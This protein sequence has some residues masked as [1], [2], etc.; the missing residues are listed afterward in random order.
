MMKKKIPVSGYKATY[1]H[2]DLLSTCHR[3]VLFLVFIIITIIISALV[4]MAITNTA[5]SNRDIDF[6][7]LIASL[8]LLV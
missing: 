1:L 2:L 7:M 6:R 5:S 8:L 4:A 3:I